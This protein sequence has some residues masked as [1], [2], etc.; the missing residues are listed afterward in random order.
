MDAGAV[1]YDP[2]RYLPPASAYSLWP[3]W[4]YDR[5]GAGLE[6]RGFRALI[7]LVLAAAEFLVGL[8]LAASIGFTGTYLQTV[9][10]Y[11][12]SAAFGWYM[13]RA[14]WLT[15]QVPE[16]IKCARAVFDVSDTEFRQGVGRAFYWAT[17]PWAIVGLT[18]F[19]LAAVWAVAAQ[20]YFGLV[21]YM[22]RFADFLSTPAFPT[23]WH[24]HGHMLVKML[25]VDVYV[26]L[27][28]AFAVPILWASLVG[29]VA[30]VRVVRSWRVV[31]VP[32]YV[33]TA[34]KPTADYLFQA[35]FFYA[36]AIAVVAVLYVGR[37]VRHDHGYVYLALTIGLSIVGLVFLVAPFAGIGQIVERA[38]QQLG[39]DVATT[40]YR[41][42]WP[43]GT[44]TVAVDDVVT[45]ARVG[46]GYT[47]LLDLQRLMHGASEVTGLPFSVGYIVQ[48]VIIQLAPAILAV[49]L[50]A[51]H[52]FTQPLQITL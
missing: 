28:V 27:A 49:V 43:V 12:L 16:R 44:G 7:S 31:P 2:K 41:D 33:A 10:V 21:P 39:E 19:C 17:Q 9:P 20:Y 36:T 26:G 47:Q 3:N 5:L 14:R 15:L 24:T 22:S 25:I 32:A 42:I 35:A 23:E 37:D 45:R 50:V 1:S 38:R 34:V 4:I 52:V 11:L 29:M 18:F 8:A 51:T 30:S 40:Y 13:G 48:G 6:Q 46:Q